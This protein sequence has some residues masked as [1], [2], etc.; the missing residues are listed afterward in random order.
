MATSKARGRPISRRSIPG[1]PSTPR[2]RRSASASC[3]AR[4]GDWTGAQAAY[5]YAANSGHPEYAPLAA[6]NIGHLFKRQGRFRQA[7]EAYQLAIDSG[8]ADVAPWAMV[9]LGNLL[10]HYRNPAGAEACYQSAAESGHSEAAQQAAKRLE[11]LRHAR[12]AR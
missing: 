1:T 12:W 2:R 3:S 4:H 10:I 9:Y 11:A 7:R 5:W 8:H 6:R